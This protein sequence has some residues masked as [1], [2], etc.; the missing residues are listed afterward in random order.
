MS[1]PRTGS[2]VLVVPGDPQQRT[3]GYLYDRRLAEA[4]RARGWDVTLRSLAGRFPRTDEHARRSAREVLTSIDDGA[5]VVIDG[6]ALGDLPT[7]AAEH[8]RRLNLLGL[9]HHPLADEAGLDPADRAHFLESERAALAAVA[10]VVVTSR[11]TADRLRD[12]AVPR[13]RVVVAEPGNDPAPLARGGPPGAPQLLCVGAI[14]PRKAHH[15]L[16]A[17]LTELRDLEWHCHCVGSPEAAPEHAADVLAERS[18]RELE[19]RVTFTGECDAEALAE[20]Y[21]RADLLVHPALYEGYGMVVA[22]ALARGIPVLATTGGALPDTLPDG[23][24]RLVPPGDS[25]A[26]AGALRAILT[27]PALL[28]R[29]RAG[30]IRARSG[31]AGWD[32]T[33]ARF[34]AALRGGA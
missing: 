20:A 34:E 19:H 31:L 29:L 9:V 15:V 4:L 17:A 8:A 32:V 27:D 14:V 26:L 25:D 18:R 21:H 3:G 24:G 11:F 1:V 7:V 16:L 5:H 12:Y 30:A 2:L 28:S 23:A 33:A 10:R 13:E 6:L 22:E